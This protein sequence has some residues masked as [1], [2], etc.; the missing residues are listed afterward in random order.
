LSATSYNNDASD[1]GKQGPASPRRLRPRQGVSRYNNPARDAG[2][3][4]SNAPDSSSDDAEEDADRHLQVGDNDAQ[5]FMVALPFHRRSC[6][7]CLNSGKG[8]YQALSLA[9]EIKHVSDRHPY[10]QI[11]YKCTNCSKEYRSKHAALCHMPKCTGRAPAPQGNVF[12]CQQC[13]LVCTSKSGLTQHTRHRHPA[14]RNEQ[15]AAAELDRALRAAQSRT[16]NPYVKVFTDEEVRLMLELEVKFRKRRFVAKDMEPYFP[17]KTNKQLRDKRNMVSYKRIREEYLMGLGIPTLSDAEESESSAGEEDEPVTESVPPTPE[18]PREQGVPSHSQEDL[19]AEDADEFS[20]PEVPADEIGS[21]GSNSIDN[22]WSERIKTAALEHSLPEKAISQ[23]PAAVIQELQG[24]LREA[25]NGF[26]PQARLDEIYEHV[27]SY[28]VS[29][30][31]TTKDKRQRNRGR[32]R[33]AI[34][35]YVYARTQDLFK[36]NPGQLAQYVREDV[37]WLGDD[38]AQLQRDDIE[39]LYQALWNH[40]PKVQHPHWDFPPPLD[41]E[42]VLTHITLREIKTRISQ[43]KIKSAAGPDGIQKRHLN[44]WT[45]HEILHLLFNLLMCCTMQPTQWRMNRTQ[46]LLKRGK[47]P[48]LAESYRPITISS[49]LSRLYW[50]IIDQKLREHVRFHP[51]QKGFVSEAG[52]FNNVQILSELLRHSKSQHQSLVAVCLDVSKA[53]DTV[54]H[55]IIG[56]ALRMK[57]LPEPVV[58]LVEDSYKD[59]YTNI[60]QGTVEVPMKLQRGVKQG[61]PLSPFI[62]NAVLEPLLLQLESLPGYKVGELASVSS[63]AFADDIFLIATD[64]PQASALL[65]ATEEYLGRLEMKIS[66]PKCT[67]F[68]IAPTKDSW[69]VT[70]PGLTLKNGERIP[71]AAAESAFTYLG[72]K[73]SP[74]ADVKLE[75]LREEFGGALFRASR[76]SLKPHQKVE[77]ISR[78]LVPH[79]LYR[80]VVAI[81]PVKLIRQLDQELRGVIKRIC[82]LPQSTADGLLYCG[83]KDGGL[84]ILKLETIA[85]TSILKAGLKFKHS[86]DRVM[87][88]LWMNAGMASRLN[89]LAKSARVNPWP[90]NDPKDLDRHK[91]SMKRSELAKWASLVSQ[92]KSVKS[93]ADNKIANAW[94]TNK[95]LLKPGNFI[96]ALRLRANVAGDRV[97]LNRAVPQAN[98]MCRRCGAQ[99]ETLGHIL[100]ICT[101]TKVQRI[102]RHD[103]INNLIADEIT[104]KDKEAA[105]TLEPTI[106]T[107]AS[108][109]LKPDLVVQSQGRVFVVDVTVRHEDGNLL[110]QGRQ[111]KLD[112]YEP[113]L[114][115]LQEQLGALSGEVLP[116]VVGTRGALPKETIEALRKLEITDRK[117]LLTISLIALRASI[118]IYHAFMDYN[119]RPRPVGGVNYPHR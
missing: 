81:P 41:T 66:A 10:T 20:S 25:A 102:D 29:E 85:V 15:R 99:L 52:C 91:S 50:G 19:D 82:H 45:V 97:A 36:R 90:T 6:G 5:F 3:G 111:E 44:R 69:Y 57:G 33:R 27:L 62:F 79:Y 80:L 89:S 98:L 86:P 100:G 78:Y 103:E 34:R 114:P 60:K 61:D 23:E 71:A 13:G 106:R 116:V 108:G 2:A 76:L 11:I 43:T 118:R 65:R 68:Q 96:S 58:R 72:V 32:G 55:Q 26:F 18:L 95:K 28:L 88:A 17:N 87:Q 115:T 54:P 105:V 1:L 38:Q 107:P 77:L 40:K 74:W 7:V 64:V 113:L 16:R 94:L 56:P 117:T 31:R 112:K 92:G 9:D 48:A 37:R 110:A 12:K 51:R 46:L 63:L 101:S 21:S 47:D 84:G 67:S 22:G 8:N 59:L 83:M 73:I 39:R 35:R 24:A 4:P 119:A 53:F 30:D 49:M 109:N 14:L 75:G 93:F 42:D 104:K 70:D